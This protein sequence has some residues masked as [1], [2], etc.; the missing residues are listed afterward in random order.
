[1]A[2]A[3]KVNEVAIVNEANIQQMTLRIKGTSPLVMNKFSKKAKEEMMWGMATPASEKKSKA[4]RPVRN[5]DEEFVDAQHISTAG[6]IG[7]PCPGIRAAMIDACRTAN[8][9]MARTKMAVFIVPDGFDADEGTPLTRLLAPAPQRHESLVR[10]ANGSANISIRA[11][12][13][14]WEADVTV[15]FD[16]D[17]ISASSVVNLLNRAGRQV[18]LLEGRPFSKNSYGQGWGTFTVVANDGKA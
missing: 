15:E 1:M 8:L 9:V 10:M 2:F 16:A 5:Y 18:G 13:F 7:V 6:W 3:K 11:R 4:A 12:W 14:E 17:M